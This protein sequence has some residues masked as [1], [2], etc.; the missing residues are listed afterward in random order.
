MGLGLFIVREIVN[1]H[2]GAITVESSLEKGTVFAIRLPRSA[3]EAA[4]TAP[5]SP[6]S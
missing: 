5:R 2:L 4:P 3:P 1:G 6:P